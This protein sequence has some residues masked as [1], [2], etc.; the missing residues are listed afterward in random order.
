M[1]FIDVIG[2]CVCVGVMVC[3]GVCFNH[4]MVCVLLM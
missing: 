1:C 4:V 2:V 3:V